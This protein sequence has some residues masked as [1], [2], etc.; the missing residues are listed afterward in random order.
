MRRSPWIPTASL[1][2]V[3]AVAACGK[4]PAPAPAALSPP[5]PTSAP[6]TALSEADWTACA[7]PDV[8]LPVPAR[9]VVIAAPDGAGMGA[10][11]DDA[12]H[13]MDITVHAT[14]PLALMLTAGTPTSWVIHAA[15][16][17]Q[18]LAVLASGRYP[19]RVAGVPTG[20]PR[21]ERSQMLGERCGRS[22]L[23]EPDPALPIEVATQRLFGKAPDEI[24]R[25][26][27]LSVRIGEPESAAPTRAITSAAAEAAVAA[28]IEEALRANVL[29]KAA[30]DDL[31][32]WTRRYTQV[33]GRAPPDAAQ[34]RMAQTPAYVVRAGFDLPPGLVG[35]QVLIFL[36]DKGTPRP[37]G[38]TGYSM[39]LDIENGSCSGRTCFLISQR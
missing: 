36:V 12:R 10:S 19:Q 15:P 28:A 34:Q 27:G 16:Q 25:A 30:T 4:T 14:E 39:I 35:M 9:L 2:V 11:D 22:W 33:S 31:A 13:I 7:L 32:R 3:L 6:A 8:A 26:E 20:T 38:D 17:A 23:A 21:A 29:R 24:V 5:A 18:I 37:R 1:F